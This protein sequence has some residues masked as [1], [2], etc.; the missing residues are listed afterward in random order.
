MVLNQPQQFK[1][2]R[3]FADTDVA[4]VVQ[5]TDIEGLSVRLADMKIPDPPKQPLQMPNQPD[6][7]GQP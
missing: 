6:N 3:A 7:P 5:T 4:V 1:P 2:L